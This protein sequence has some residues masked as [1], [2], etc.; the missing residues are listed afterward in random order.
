MLIRLRGGGLAEHT[1]DATKALAG[2]TARAPMTGVYARGSLLVRPV[3]LRDVLRDA[4][5]FAA[6]PARCSSLP[7][8]RTICGS[9]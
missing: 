1:A 3:R 4:A 7:S 5:A 6:R 9:S 2:E 8:M